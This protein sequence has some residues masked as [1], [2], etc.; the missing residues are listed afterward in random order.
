M[1]LSNK[2]IKIVV[3]AFKKIFKS[4]AIYLFGSRVD[5]RKR[6]GDI[7]L[8]LVLDKEIDNV[9]DKKME[10]LLQLDKQLGEQKIDVVISTDKN[11]EIEKR[12]L[13]EGINL[14]QYTD[15]RIQKY[16][17]ECQKHQIRINEAFNEIKDIFPLS[18]KRY[19]Q[20]DSSEIKNIDQYFFRFS[21]M[22]EY[23][24]RGA[25]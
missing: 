16:L 14:M 21:K 23:D 12:A 10:F 24:R 19:T 1:R 25:F 17:N 7:D 18:G 22:Q 13:K 20:L 6:G 11:R 4:G 9:Y 2:E 3:F 5:D 8:Y 15:I